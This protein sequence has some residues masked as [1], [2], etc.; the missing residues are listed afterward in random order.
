MNT[1]DFIFWSAMALLGFAG[2]A[3]YSGLETGAYR[4][5]RI[6]LQNRAHRG[7]SSAIFLRH[8]IAHPPIMLGTLLIGNN[9]VNFLGTA[10]LTR[11]FDG[12]GL[13]EGQVIVANIL[14]VTPL[15]FIFGET[16]P[17]DLFGAYSD[18]LMYRL[19]PVL[20]VSYHV[21]RWTGLLF[22]I[23]SFTRVMFRIM[24]DRRG[25]AAFHPRRQV[26][27][28]VK[29]GVGYGLLTDDQSAIVER[30]M[31]LSKRTVVDEMIPWNSV[32]TIS[33][34]DDADAIW[35]IA[36]RTSR[37]RF[38]VV[39]DAGHLVGILHVMDALRRGRDNCPTAGELMRPVFKVAHNLPLRKALRTMQTEHFALAVVE[40]DGKPVGVV[41]IKDLVEPITGELASW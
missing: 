39:D 15:L 38:P 32:Q 11:L 10:S 41:S 18:R 7:L 13:S 14:I 1:G 35:D 19:S 37:S 8:M 6:R 27:L 29:E 23:N 28:L 20:Q 2:S 17:K 36:E 12:W 3:L 21:F 5:N 31:S 4:L 26:E 33:P 25:T 16:L 34:D 22:V 30:V 9:I 40:R 24:G